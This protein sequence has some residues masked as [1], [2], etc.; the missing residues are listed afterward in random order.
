MQ[1]PVGRARNPTPLASA[2][3]RAWPAGDEP[4]GPTPLPVS[5]H[6]GSG[7]SAGAGG[8]A[9]SLGSASKKASTSRIGGSTIG[10]SVPSAGAAA[11][12]AAGAPASASAGGACGTRPP[13]STRRRPPMRALY[14]PARPVH[15][16]GTVRTLTAPA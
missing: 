5:A 9:G 7:G 15:R 14:G 13:V 6:A 8:S 1:G 4:A 16:A 11:A 10:G 12:P 3:G 2:T